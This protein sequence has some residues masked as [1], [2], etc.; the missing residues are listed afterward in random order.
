MKVPRFMI[1][2]VVIVSSQSLL[3]LLSLISICWHCHHYCH[4]DCHRC[5]LLIQ[6]RGFTSIR[7]TNYNCTEKPVPVC[8]LLLHVA[9]TC[10][11]RAH[12]KSS[13]G[14]SPVSGKSSIN[15]ACSIAFNYWRH[16]LLVTTWTS[17]PSPEDYHFTAITPTQ[18]E[19]YDQHG[20]RLFDFTAAGTMGF[21]V[22]GEF[23]EPTVGTLP[24]TPRTH[25]ALNI[26]YNDYY[27]ILTEH[28]TRQ[29]SEL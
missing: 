2:V 4:R 15:G 6:T 8:V 7:Q 10:S 5:W 13:S 21:K 20:K 19:V 9:T 18:L 1:I 25:S 22:K 11:P 3:F 17:K 23:L 28:K 24:P 27:E 16:H 12:E 26:G 29:K 14:T